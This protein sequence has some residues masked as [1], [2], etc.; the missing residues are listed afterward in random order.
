MDWFQEVVIDLNQ[1][2]CRQGIVDVLTYHHANSDN[3]VD[4][5]FWDYFCPKLMMN[6]P[7]RDSVLG[8]PDIDGD[9]IGHYEDEDEMEAFRAGQYAL[10]RDVQAA[11]G[12]DFL[13]IF[14]GN[15]AHVDSNF[16]ALGDGM[17]YER[18]PIMFGSGANVERALD[19]NRYNNL[20][21]ARRWPRQ[22]N[23][24]PYIILANN[25]SVGFC[26]H[27]G[28][29]YRLNLADI[30]R[31]VALMCDAAVVYA[32][33]KQWTY[34]WPVVELRL[35]RALGPPIRDG[36]VMT[37]Y[38]RNGRVTL[39]FTTGGHPLPFDFEIVQDGRVVQA[40]DPPYHYP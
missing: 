15:L 11:M 29:F 10:V 26:D 19:H 2:G 25:W 18:F 21:A 35:G 9:G 30:N 16:A 20:F 36:R 14:N 28:V 31:V 23:G 13:M 4:G 27:E 39:T 24:G 12:E 6:F 33:H 32:P 17:F 3:P 40:L 37:R 34:G 38:F 8:E 7:G 5:I 1:P 22:R